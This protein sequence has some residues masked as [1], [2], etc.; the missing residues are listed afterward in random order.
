MKSKSAAKTKFSE[1]LSRI[2]R[3]KKKKAL[4]I[5]M[6]NAHSAKAEYN[7]GEVVIAPDRLSWKLEVDVKASTKKAVETWGF[8]FIEAMYHLRA[9]LDTAVY[10]IA[11][12]VPS[13]DEKT[14]K[15]IKFPICDSAKEWR[16]AKRPLKLLPDP[17]QRT[18][19][20]LQPFKLKGDPKSSL[21]DRLLVLQELSNT[22][23]HNLQIVPSAA[24]ADLEHSFNVGFYDT[25]GA[26]RSE[27]CKI[28]TSYDH[29]Q[30]IITMSQ[31]VPALI[32]SV[33]YDLKLNFDTHIVL[34]DGR[35]FDLLY[36]LEAEID[37][38]E[39]VLRRLSEA[40]R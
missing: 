10:S 25:D 34:E 26:E 11:S 32:H 17:Y 12:E 27:S 1:Q 14:L 29:K 18:L 21:G 15:L 36:L 31:S 38:V 8:E 7:A 40:N 37:C 6:I 4:I 13:M 24:A 35:L 30:G 19:E 9:A 39:H 5:E 28:D 23:K 20:G 33:N 16:S 3:A 22:D 2:D